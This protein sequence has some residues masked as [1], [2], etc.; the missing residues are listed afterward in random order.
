MKRLLL[1]ALLLVLAGCGSEPRAMDPQIRE[2]LLSHVEEVKAAAENND[3]PAAEMALGE[4]HRAIAEAQARGEL[5][6]EAARALL[7]ATERVAEDVRTMPLP[8]PPA[9]VTV[10]VTPDPPVVPPPLPE[11][12]VDDHQEQVAKLEEYRK[13]RDELREHWR[14][15]RENNGNGNGN[16][17]D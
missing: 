6:T 7:T 12:R 3:R 11:I 4:L 17:D 16:N 5:T 8:E 13:Q 2:Q 1:P 10:T 14:K 15:V 9:P